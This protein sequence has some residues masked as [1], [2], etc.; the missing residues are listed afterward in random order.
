MDDRYGI[1]QK[2]L[3]TTGGS[4]RF[5]FQGKQA[6][7]KRI[8]V[9]VAHKVRAEGFLDADKAQ[10]PEVEGG[11]F[12]QQELDR[13]K[14]LNVTPPFKRFYYKVWPLVQSL[15]ELL[16]HAPAVVDML[17]ALLEDPVVVTQAG[18]ETLQL[19]SVLARDLQ[20]SF[21]PHF[22]RVSTAL[23]GLIASPD[24][25][26]EICG[27]V[28]RCLGFL[29]KFV[30]RPLSKDMAA[31]RALYAP[32]LGHKRDFARKMAAQTLAPAVRRLKPKA[33]RRHAKQ[34]VG[35]LA[36]G[37]V[38]AAAGGAEAGA[39]RLRADTLDGCS[40]L[41]FFSAKGVHGRTHSQAPVLLRV[42]LDSLL[43]PKLSDTNVAPGERAG[44][45]DNHSRRKELERGWCF[46][47]ASA[48][49]ALL[50]EHVRSPHSAELWLELHYGLGTATAR[51]RAS[52]PPP[53]A[54]TGDRGDQEESAECAAVRRTA[55]LLSQAVGHMG[56]ILLREE[57]IG[58]KQAALLAEAL[59]ELTSPEIFWQPGTSPGCRRAVVELLA[60]SL[61]GL[62]KQQRLVKVM[63]R[64][65]RAAAAAAAPP[66]PVRG[67]RTA[68]NDTTAAVESL[69]AVDTHP[70]LA[71]ARS[72]LG[73]VGAERTEN[74]PPPM[75]VTRAVALR[76]LLEA[77]S[78][79]LSGQAGVALEVLVRVIHGTGVG[80]V[81]A[82][83]KV[84]GIGARR[85]AEVGRD[86]D[87][88]E[89][90]EEEEEDEEGV[91]ALASV[92]GAEGPGCLPMG[93]AEGQQLVDVCCASVEL[94]MTSL[95][96]S[97]S[98]FAPTASAR[99]EAAEPP[100]LAIEALLAACSAALNGTE[101]G[102]E[103]PTPSAVAQGTGTPVADPGSGSGRKRRKRGEGKS[104]GGAAV[105]SAAGTA[106]EGS[107]GGGSD[108]GGGGGGGDQAGGEG[109]GDEV[110]VLRAYAL[111]AGVGLCCLLPGGDEG[112][113]RKE[114]LGRLVGWHGR[115][116]EWLSAC[117]SSISTLRAVA[118]LLRA[119]RA[120]AGG[121]G[122]PPPCLS[123]DA[124]LP[125]IAL[126]EPNLASDSRLLRLSTVRVLA[127][128]DPL[129]LTEEPAAAGGV[130]LP[131][132]SQ[133]ESSL[134]ELA[135]AV[136]ELP[137]SVAAERDLMWRLG[138]LEVL[139]RSGRLPRPYAR[140]LATH[141]LGL[142][143]VKF[144][145]VWP[146]AVAI[147]S[148]LYRRSHQRE[149]V[150]EPVRAAL[151]KVMPPPATRQ[152]VAAALEEQQRAALVTGLEENQQQQHDD[153]AAAGGD[154]S[155]ETAA[156]IGAAAGPTE[157]PENGDDKGSNDV[158]PVNHHP[159][160]PRP[161]SGLRAAIPPPKPWVP[162]LLPHAAALDGGPAKE[163]DLPVAL[164]GVFQDETVRTGLQPESGEVPLWASTDADSAFAQVWGVLSQCPE[165]LQQH[166]RTIVPLFLGFMQYQ[167]LGDAAF[168]DDPETRSVGVSSHLTPSER[169]SE[170]PGG[171]GPVVRRGGKGEGG[172]GEG[173]TADRRSVRGRLVALLGVFAA[174][175][176]PKS[177]YKQRVLFGVYRA[178]M[179]MPDDK[180]AG[181]AL[182]CML[183]YRP[184]Y[185]A[186]LEGLMNDETFRDELV[187]FSLESEVPGTV[188]SGDVSI[189]SSG[190][191]AAADPA[192][193]DPLHRPR[194]I[195]VVIR[196]VYGR[197]AASG[198]RGR[199]GGH[200][201]PAARRAA[202]L[203]FLSGLASEE[204]SELFALMV[205][206]F[207]TPAM[208]T[209][210]S[211]EEQERDE[212]PAAEWEEAEDVV[213]AVRVL[214][215]AAGITRARVGGVS[216]SRQ[217][218]FLKMARE[219]AKQLGQKALPYVETVL[220]LVLVLLEHS[221]AS[222][223][224]DR[225]KADAGNSSS[226][227]QAGDMDVDEE[228]VDDDDEAGGTPAASSVVAGRRY[229]ST[230]K[231]SPGA[232]RTLCLRA[233]SELFSQFS[234]TFDFA[235]H[236]GAL[237][238]A[239][240]GPIARLPASTIGATRKPALLAFAETLSE[241]EAL[242]P[243]FSPS[244]TAGGGGGEALIPAVLDCISA[245]SASGRVAGPA[246]V[247]A[248]L[249][250]VERLLRHDGGSLL[251]PHL[252][253]L[254]SNF[255]ARLSVRD[256]SGGSGRGFDSHTEQ[257]LAI[258]A[259]VAEMATSSDPPLGSGGGGGDGG[260][261]DPA[262][263]SKLVALLIPS[264]QP[265]HRRGSDEAKISI[266]RAVAALALR[267]DSP[268]ARKAWPALSRLL[269]PAGAR[270]SGMAA[271]APRGELVRAL[272]ALAGRPDLAAAAAAAVAL[273]ADLNARDA[274]ALDE[275][276][277]GRVVPAFNSLSEGTGW[278]DIVAAGGAAESVPVRAREEVVAAGS[279]G[280][281]LAAT[282]VAQHCLHAMHDQE[283]ALR[284]A[285]GAALKRLVRES[286]AA[287]A[288]VGRDS[289][290][291]VGTTTATATV[292]CPWEG[293]MRTVVMPGLRAGMACRV[294]AVRKGYISLL[295]ETV[296]VY[297]AAAAGGG[298]G[299]G[300]GGDGRGERVGAAAV[301]PTDLWAL[302]RADDPES[303]FFL[304]A[305]H[306]QVH[307]RARALAKARK[308]IE[309]FE[310]ASAA[311]EA[312]AGRPIGAEAAKSS[313]AGLVGQAVQLV[314]AI[315]RHLPW[316]HYNSALRGLMQ[317]VAGGKGESDSHSPE[318]ER[319]M[320]G[321]VCQV[322]DGFHFALIPP[323]V[324]A[325]P[326]AASAAA[327][328][329]S[330]TAVVVS[331]GDGAAA[332][333]EV[334]AGGGDAVW[335][336]VNDR[337][338]GSLRS[339]LVKEVRGKSGGKERVLR[340]PVAVGMLNLIR[341]LPTDAFELQLKPL[342]MT[343]CQSLKS[344]D[345]NARD[346]A[347]DT[348]AKMARDLGPDYLQQVVIT[349]LRTCLV[350]G[351]QLHVRT[352]T[353]HTVL[354]TVADS[355]KPP[356]PPSVDVRNTKPAE[357]ASSSATTDA[358][359]AAVMDVDGEESS[360]AALVVPAVPSSLVKPSFD[361]CIPE[362]VEL[363]MEDLFGESAAAK[364]AQGANVAS[365]KMK[366]AKGQKAY[367][368][369]EIAARTMLFRPTFTVLAPEDAASA[370][371]VH[372]LVGP[373]LSLL[374]GCE[375][376]RSV[377][378]ANEAL[379]RI[380]M[381]LAANPSVTESEMLLY[382]H[383]TVAP[384][385][386]PQT[387]EE[388]DDDEVEEGD[389][390]DSSDS[391]SGAEGP[392]AARKKAKGG[393][394]DGGASSSARKWMASE[395]NLKGHSRLAAAGE[396]RRREWES[397]QVLDGASAPKHTGRDRHD[398]RAAGRQR[399][400][401]GGSAASSPSSS[402]VRGVDLGD[403]AA[404]GAVT[405]A[406]GLLHSRLKAEA[407]ARGAGRR[408]AAMNRRG[409]AVRA[410]AD[411]FV[412]LLTRCIGKN[413]HTPVVLLSLKSLG[414]LLHWD[415]P[416]M[417]RCA[418]LVGR[419][420]LARL[421]RGGVGGIRGE[422]GQACFKALSMLFKSQVQVFGVPGEE[423]GRRKGRGG[424]L[425]GLAPKQLRA[426]L[427]VLQMAVAETEHQNA[428]FTLIKAVVARRVMLPEVYDL[429]T[430]LAE[431]AVTSHRP[432]LRVT[433]GQTFLTFLLHYPLGE[434][435]LQ[436]HL[437]QIVSGVSY[438]HA[439]GRLAALNLCSQLLRRLPEPNL[440][441]LSSVFY[442]ALVV[443]LVSDQAAECRA[444]ASTA[445]RTL[446]DRVSPAVFQELLEFT[447]Q[448]FGEK[449][450]GAPSGAGGGEEDPGLRRTAAQACG[451][452]VQARPELVRK[453]AGTGGGGRLPWMLSALSL[454]LPR[455]AAEVIAAARSAGWGD[456]GGSVG[457]AAGSCGG[458]GGADGDWEGVYHAVL[459]IGKVFDALPGACN[460]ALS[461]GGGG[462]DDG[463]FDR[464]LEVLLYPH[465]WVRL[466]AARVWG[467]FFSKRDP[468]TL[469]V[470]TG[471]GG[472]QV[473]GSQTP[474][475]VQGGSTPGKL[476]GKGRGQRRGD[477][478]GEGAGVGDGG[479]EFLRRRRV[480]FRLCQNLCSQLN[481][482]QVD[483]KLTEQCVKNLVFIGR[484]MHL[485]PE[486][487]FAEDAG[488]EEN[489][490]GTESPAIEEAS[491]SEG[492]DDDGGDTAAA[493]AADSADSSPAG[494]GK[495]TT[496]GAADPL[497]WVF[498]RMSHMVVH[499]GEARRRAVFSWFL[500]M[501]AVHD[502]AVSVAHLKL[503]LLPLRRAVLDAEAG[504]VEHKAGGPHAGGGG[505]GGGGGSAAAEK[506]QTAAELATEVME[507]LE[508]KV[509][510]GRFLEALTGVNMEI[511]RKRVERKRQRAVEKATDPVAAAERR[512][513][514]TEAAKVRYHRTEFEG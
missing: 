267:V 453:A 16:H 261:V 366:E 487:C 321:A 55:D 131:R 280:G 373:V 73:G 79:P 135:E 185:L 3:N 308:A 389:S 236:S 109:R 172:G 118:L 493:T 58:V 171:W 303:D 344:R 183:A 360:A 78:G 340:A 425:F 115:A 4:N 205:R 478:A 105:A 213:R 402:R 69:V 380:G 417:K 127:R 196:L 152:E 270:P 228:Q 240:A 463:L 357:P 440:D 278:A 202:V 306:M 15:P 484:A 295:R 356:N 256:T 504:G 409:E 428:T 391:D 80:L 477:V 441:Q 222:S 345:S 219:V 426:L 454:M 8:D 413:P 192:T 164:Q 457:A 348:L 57:A 89:V 438:E 274:A 320:I 168:P 298:G 210:S 310:A 393:S 382:V 54:P 246:V 390:E 92:A 325:E 397:V 189:I 35:A 491:D 334:V 472:G 229:P 501:V 437:N 383:A 211:S 502:P 290:S 133:G 214:E 193:I 144:S 421:V 313:E 216:A 286:A 281:A 234:T 378:K 474:K 422:M 323:G 264:L 369:F 29:L 169:A 120:A 148:A 251:T 75:R 335:R 444:A 146:R 495:A 329:S 64:V 291:V 411:P 513:G 136:E 156:E 209:S 333:A 406:M 462:G 204:L 464:L 95:K 153:D 510:S 70:A 506:E 241:N 130:G 56:G 467:S 315:A 140:L 97:H 48:V 177:L 60:V 119:I 128:Y 324:V 125:V 5:K 511:S 387:S 353:L 512:R 424:G 235:A 158:E 71:L 302:A 137:V 46:E 381:G 134:L 254:I 350:T 365:S 282:P 352:F 93:V 233:L 67:E 44:G 224:A 87:E 22:P 470:T 14:E 468:G 72:L 178:L 207:L 190:S 279:L 25:S 312:A 24:V 288:T 155:K 287:A 102:S 176:G 496:S 316:T 400:T 469:A 170:G 65:I 113:A 187:T 276:D 398:G 394:A 123:A 34:L 221:N 242:L 38:E 355:Y 363:L 500:A 194:L 448:W 195:P 212:G 456:A 110:K 292:R 342:L 33:M 63:P 408:A 362:V 43:P 108:G 180:V 61:C 37:N 45:E 372:A 81:F 374:E 126:L 461:G 28:L 451:I 447:G 322:L 76:P 50:V 317:Q 250:F 415:L 490:S 103:N 74:K 418:P 299:G 494:G 13:S 252:N 436:F 445:V 266:L 314:G 12:F 49:L 318:K 275:P 181:L 23:I 364:E 485:N 243:T 7:A 62:H 149:V 132:Q 479:Q 498:N 399:P 111:E 191:A 347:R 6:R 116:M 338:L 231:I 122:T 159:Q 96:G 326:A 395:G 186:N 459:S 410:M 145:A 442:L 139:G 429:M 167:Y 439:E 138:Q 339:L 30:A 53:P 203:A 107:S 249:T 206:P 151:R 41:L 83:D 10:N 285:A 446:L 407:T 166:S 416:S 304:N 503:M 17:L 98:S 419:H 488:E 36:A 351:Y 458:G 85:R 268:G 232:L 18:E 197:L 471:G 244:S 384:F 182:R 301:V 294:E 359:D 499:K 431:L 124:S 265:D 9:D 307:R 165:L 157:G 336:A 319:A 330:S 423:A 84:G 375:N 443:R 208:M 247:G 450:A 284:G 349:E 358:A 226:S 248:A 11:S 361:A 104:G 40:Q 20:S 19:L 238:P 434:K 199:A 466:A 129:P 142:L 432:T 237:W 327:E 371:S 473:E 341:R 154:Q 174:A 331:N 401:V 388:D 51:H 385:L 26:P 404:L 143:R 376:A 435:R 39:R 455:R 492:V 179:V 370:S 1:G 161:S 82:G 293:L 198:S 482:S 452:F 253:H 420:V 99:R 32:L 481:R 2:G 449:D 297:Q 68:D 328:P 497:R 337:L 160:Q 258:L 31:V 414:Y 27:R 201:G 257:G 42:L 509:G 433:S 296:S 147:V 262:S 386:L 377:G 277:F 21:F 117:P 392:T 163:M 430:K 86:D 220:G 91:G 225:R 94:A 230:G 475:R 100:L 188:G 101:A 59:A 150:W 486:L 367:D 412:P 489:A 396:K 368:S 141:A 289:T 269:G 260:A 427:V 273:V 227:N 112:A 507:L 184:P 379:T 263:M 239:L 354:K 405:L 66:A 114:T 217:A 215:R 272:E 300:G 283:V 505:S 403:P 332:P 77:C 305:C 255:A 52:L 223:E 121:D 271:A 343:V 162:R 90:E 175:P 508:E 460:T 200:G 309:D 483:P 465:A 514:R 259:R 106:V 245:G 88:S 346:T 480:L 218:G 311:A 476:K 47:L 173:R